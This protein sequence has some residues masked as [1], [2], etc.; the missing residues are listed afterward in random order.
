MVDYDD[1][2]V[3]T[4]VE[5]AAKGGTIHEASPITSPTR[6]AEGDIAAAFS[7]AEHSNSE[8]FTSTRSNRDGTAWR[9]GSLFSR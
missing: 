1:L 5:E 9:P 8:S 7:S 6:W 3:V 4:D 2:P